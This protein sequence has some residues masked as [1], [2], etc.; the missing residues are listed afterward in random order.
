MYSSIILKYILPAL[1]VIVVVGHLTSTWRH[2]DEDQSLGIGTHVAPDSQ[3]RRSQ[4]QPIASANANAPVTSSASPDIGSVSNDSTTVSDDSSIGG[5]LAGGSASKKNVQPTGS[6]IPSST[7][8]SSPQFP[9]AVTSKGI[10]PSSLQP[11]VMR[12]GVMA[13]SPSSQQFPASSSTSVANQ[14]SGGLGVSTTISQNKG[15]QAQSGSGVASDRTVG[16]DA[17]ASLSDTTSTTQN[18]GKGSTGQPGE[19]SV[20]YDSDGSSGKASSPV[21][22]S[23]AQDLAKGSGDQPAGGDA[24][25]GSDGSPKEGSLSD[26]APKERPFDNSGSDYFKKLQEYRRDFGGQALNE[27]MFTGS[28]Q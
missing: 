6:V 28:N 21:A 18:L 7:V 1:L 26:T 22:K 27:Q 20:S 19:G 14:V 16:S 10:Q 13:S 15:S 25:N 8:N 12:S 5:I 9:K 11:S 2:L 4:P 23:P 3:F 17:G 24:S